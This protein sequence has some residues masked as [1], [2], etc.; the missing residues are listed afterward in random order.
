MTRLWAHTVQLRAAL[1]EGPAA[2][3]RRT[4][5][6]RR[7]DQNTTRPAAEYQS[8]IMAEKRVTI[9]NA[10]G[11]KMVG[12]LHDTGSEVAILAL[13][14]MHTMHAQLPHLPQAQQ[15]HIGRRH[16]TLQR[17]LLA[18]SMALAFCST[19]N[20]NS[21]PTPKR[22]RMRQ[23]TKTGCGLYLFVIQTEQHPQHGH[24]CAISKLTAGSWLRRIL[25]SCAM[26]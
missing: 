25:L 4:P 26:A 13:H 18:G 5:E 20:C 17:P 21:P 24:S 2:L 10:K 16:S 6:G 11:E 1:S 9:E 7:S 12:I 8:A 14:S 3:T 23:H 19:V 15:R 22:V